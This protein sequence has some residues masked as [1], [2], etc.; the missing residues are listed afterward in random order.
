MHLVLMSNVCASHF[1]HPGTASVSASVSV[2][3]FICS[4]C[5]VKEIVASFAF[6][7]IVTEW[8]LLTYISLLQTAAVLN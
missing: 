1:C 5:I 6:N 4:L 3:H 2:F 7:C 8:I